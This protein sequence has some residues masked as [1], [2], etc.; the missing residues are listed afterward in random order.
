M[1]TREQKGGI[2]LLALL[3]A[4]A[5]VLFGK[6]AAGASLYTESTKPAGFDLT[7]S[8]YIDM[9]TPYAQM[10]QDTYGVPVDVTLA[11]GGLENGWASSGIFKNSLNAFGIQADSSWTGDT[12]TPPGDPNN[13][14]FRKYASV[15]DSFM[16]Y[17]R[18]LK[19]NSRY[20]KAFDYPG[21]SILFATEIATAGYAQD[22][23]YLNSLL[24]A[25]QLIQQIRG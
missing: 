23:N 22:P 7:P 19:D 15:K 24:K 3:G 16:D 13:A 20:K 2:A 9:Y 4:G 25:V 5:F 18:F 1:A 14:P 11:E 6:G 21:D 8:Q 17:G 10:V 12:Y